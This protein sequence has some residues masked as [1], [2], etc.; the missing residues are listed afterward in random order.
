M[1]SKN[2]SAINQSS[3]NPN[4]NKNNS[5]NDTQKR[6]FIKRLFDKKVDELINV[7]VY[8]KTK[9]KKMKDIIDKKSKQTLLL[10]QEFLPK[11]YHKYINTEEDIIS[12]INDYESMYK[13]PI[14]SMAL[15]HV[16]DDITQ[17]SSIT[18]K[19]I[20]T[21]GNDVNLVDINEEFYSNIN[22]NEHIWL[23]AMKTAMV[24]TCFVRLYYK[25]TDYTGGIKF[26]EIEN[27][28]LRYIPL[29]FN[30]VLIKYYDKYTSELLEP[31]EVVV[32]RVNTMNDS[33]V[34]DDYYDV[35]VSQNN[36][37]SPNKMI[38]TFAYG[39]SFYE[40]VRRIWKQRILV[41]DSLL[42][43]RLEN[44]PKTT[45]FKLAVN[46]LTEEDSS[47][48]VDHYADLLSYDHKTI[49]DV[50]NIIR[51][52][53]SSLGYGAKIILPIGEVGDL[54]IEEKGG[55][56]EIAPLYDLERLDRIFYASLRV[57]P[58]FLGMTE[59]LPG[60][61]GESALLRLEIR[62][63][64]VAKKLQYAIM[65][66]CKSISYYNYL[67][68]NLPIDYEKDFDVVMNVISTAE[69][70]ESKSIFNSS[71]EGF[72]SFIDVLTS[73]KEIMT[74]EAINKDSLKDLIKFLTNKIL[75]INDFDWNGFFD[76]YIEEK[77]EGESESG[78][79][80]LDEFAE[81]EP[82][83]GE[84]DFFA[85]KK[86]TKKPILEG[87]TARMFFEMSE[88]NRKKLLNN[89]NTFIS[90]QK[91]NIPKFAYNNNL[92]SMKELLSKDNNSGYI[93][94]HMKK[95]EK[96]KIQ[97]DFNK[98]IK[99]NIKM[100]DISVFD[101]KKENFDIS[102]NYEIKETISKKV[103]IKDIIHTED[104]YC[105]EDIINSNY[106]KLTLYEYNKKYYVNY[107]NGCRL[108]KLINEKKEDNMFNIVVLNNKK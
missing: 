13:D 26:I 67:S 29:E 73:V 31:F 78:D 64:R 103:K 11:F 40:N 4:N 76:N 90:R 19:R 106:D 108:F 81:E 32:F 77:P 36:G 57:P 52:N 96:L 69:E 35:R 97:E 101:V 85:N 22:L 89:I 49:N 63:A 43:A 72:N 50:E 30:G 100:F 5:G 84:K 98:I 95:N 47:S 18:K 7:D 60:A 42:L 48:M 1:S 37:S 14:L 66:G 44:A 2:R 75:N 65:S 15:E 99:N 51:G 54:S 102:N 23:I 12:K 104:I 16:V 58:A 83:A 94:E 70:E 24:G 20:W 39:S 21:V 27:N 105:V 59:D 71:I 62:Y 38:N 17:Y 28:V 56:T 41:E 53:D 25:N 74:D 86:R 55:D 79:D 107:L 88:Y 3:Y 46:G 87:K 61:L 9:I 6:S 92:K 45:F 80:E 33:R 91:Y 82:S 34:F 68:L 10:S 93:V 8:N